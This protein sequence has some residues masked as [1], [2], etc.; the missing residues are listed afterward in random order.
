M[1]CYLFTHHIYSVY[2]LNT[3]N[4][5]QL[6]GTTPFHVLAHHTIVGNQVIARGKGRTLV[7]S[8]LAALTVSNILSDTKYCYKFPYCRKNASKRYWLN[9]KKLSASL[10]V[11]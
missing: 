1:K 6:I 8:L 3:P 5:F 10:L 4:L 7:R 11:V 9:G 2:L